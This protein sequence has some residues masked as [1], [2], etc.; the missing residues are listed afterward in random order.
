[1]IEEN[2]I[3][4][5]GKIVQFPKNVKAK[6]A[7]TFLENIK[8]SKSKLWYFVIEKDD[9]ELQC[10]KYNNKCGVNLKKFVED[11]KNYYTH[12]DKMTQYVNDLIVEGSDKFSIIKNIQNV[13]IDGKKLIVI[14]TEDLIKLLK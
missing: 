4:L 6:K 2:K 9:N 8:I 1:M 13:E 7:Y 14:L 12:D 11:L 10:I 5:Y 3:N